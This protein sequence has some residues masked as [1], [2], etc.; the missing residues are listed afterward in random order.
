MIDIAVS[1]QAVMNVAL[2]SN[3][4]YKTWI[5]VKIYS[6]IRIFKFNDLNFMETTDRYEYVNYYA[7]L[8]FCDVHAFLRYLHGQIKICSYFIKIKCYGNL[9]TGCIKICLII[10]RASN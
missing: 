3:F 1:E 7:T 5:F 8:A 10:W 4:T 2:R 6:L 9:N